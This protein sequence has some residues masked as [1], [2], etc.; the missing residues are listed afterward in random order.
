[1]K[2][3]PIEQQL[4]LGKLDAFLPLVQYQP[5]AARPAV[6]P[7]ARDDLLAHPRQRVAP[8]LERGFE[9]VLVAGLEGGVVQHRRL[10]LLQAHARVTVDLWKR[11]SAC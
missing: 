3:L 2:L 5:D 9:E 8:A 4:R 11:L 1:M 6:Q 10:G 7:A